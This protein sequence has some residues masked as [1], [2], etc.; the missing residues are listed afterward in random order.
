MELLN[1]LTNSLIR[2]E[3]GYNEEELHK[4]NEKL[5]AGLNS[6]QQAVYNAV[7]DSILKKRGDYFLFIDMEELE[8][9]ICTKQLL[10]VYVQRNI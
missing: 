8:R 3:T 10:P 1:Q 2:E 7:M 5:F 6:D 4:E 9:P